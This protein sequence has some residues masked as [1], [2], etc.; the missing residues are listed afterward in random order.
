MGDYKVFQL[1]VYVSYDW[2]QDWYEQTHEFHY[3]IQ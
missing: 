2:R 1:Y 3:G